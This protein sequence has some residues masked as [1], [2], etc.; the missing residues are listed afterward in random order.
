MVGSSVLPA[1]IY[2][3]KLL[4]LFGK[5]NPL[6]KS[7]KGFSDFGGGMEK[8]ETPYETALREGGE[9][10]TGFLGDEKEIKQMIKKNGGMYKINYND[11]YHIHIFFLE[12]DENLP[13]YY[14]NNHEYL[15]KKMDNKKLKATKLFEKIEIKW[16]S[17]EEM[18]LMRHKFRHFYREI[19]DKIIENKQEIKNFLEKSPNFHSTISTRKTRKASPK[20]KKIVKPQQPKIKWQ[21]TQK[22]KNIKQRKY[23]KQKNDK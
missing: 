9:E 15:W 8:G 17:I 2:K 13:K 7:A 1:T 16:F 14:N 11:T 20:M 5:E 10:M 23:N 22:N 4:F 19:L 3:N 21:K 18:K 6:E 12:Y